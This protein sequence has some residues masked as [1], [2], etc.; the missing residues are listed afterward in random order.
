MGD[1]A[2]PEEKPV[3]LARAVPSTYNSKSISMDQTPMKGVYRT[4]VVLGGK[5]STVLVE[6]KAPSTPP[7]TRVLWIR[8]VRP[9]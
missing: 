1:W 2:L 4:K 9:L 8:G 5:T 7:I 3:L 6:K